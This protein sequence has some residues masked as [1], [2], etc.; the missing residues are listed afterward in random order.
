MKDKFLVYLA[1]PIA[2]TSYEDCTGWREYVKDMVDEEEILT[3]SP[4]RGKQFI[5]ERSRGGTV[6]QSYEDSP[7]ASIK[8]INMRDYNDVKRADAIFVDFL[9]ATK[10]S[11]GTVMEIAWA[12]AFSIPVICVM[13]KDNIHQHCM[14]NYA[15]GVIVETLEDGVDCLEALLL[16]DTKIPHLG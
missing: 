8:G 7:L 5:A 15:C 16:P 12:R 3:L 4:M 11:I 1:G 14:L 13:E 9:G 2:N 6:A 10:V